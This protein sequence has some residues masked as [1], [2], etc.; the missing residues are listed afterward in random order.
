MD[1]APDTADESM[2][3]RVVMLHARIEQQLA[4]TLQRRHNLGLSDY[5]ALTLLAAAETGELRMQELA[6]A[7]GLNQSSVSRLAAR[8][9]QAQLTRRDLCANDR[10]GVY[11][12]ITDHGRELQRTAAPTYAAAL[13]A[14]L[15]QAAAVPDLA[16]LLGPL[17]AAVAAPTA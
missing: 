11:S 4:K 2:W 8:L 16:P 12:V 17:R 3:G 15:D 10:R 5:R 14:A 9:E 13:R 1:S 6:E 7:I